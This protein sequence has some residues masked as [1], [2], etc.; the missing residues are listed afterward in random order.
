MKAIP[1][2]S[3]EGDFFYLQQ[4]QQLKDNYKKIKSLLNSGKRNLNS[5]EE[6]LSSKTYTV[7]LQEGWRNAVSKFR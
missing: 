1:E 3:R 2:L 5:I 7:G 6:S 4:R